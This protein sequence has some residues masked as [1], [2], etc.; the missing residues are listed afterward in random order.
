MKRHGL[1]EAPHSLQPSSELLQSIYALYWRDTFLGSGVAISPAVL[2]SAG[3]HYNAVKDDVGDF[4]VLV[5]P[6]QWVSVTYASKNS[7]CDLLVLWLSKPVPTYTALRG[8]LPSVSSH[9]ATVWLSP[10]P[11]HDAVVSPGVVI[12]SKAERCVIRGTVSTTGSSG[13]PVMDFFGEH[14][15]GLHL[16]SNTQDGSR[17]S[18]C[19]PARKLVALLA[20][21]GIACRS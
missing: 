5:R 11:P 19:V 8:Y 17:V 14:V 21:M 7:S 4:S 18:G 1:T 9:V 20:E 15:V 3:H 16:T 13:A 6:S 12:A 10:K 2:I